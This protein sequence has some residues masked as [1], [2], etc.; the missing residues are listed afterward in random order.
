MSIFTSRYADPSPG[1]QASDGP[2]ALSWLPS[3]CTVDVLTVGVIVL[4]TLVA[5]V[6]LRWSL[7]RPAQSP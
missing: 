1:T 6:A 4:A 7:T 5:L 2:C 3:H